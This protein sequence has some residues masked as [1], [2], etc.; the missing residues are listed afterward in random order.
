[1]THQIRQHPGTNTKSYRH[2]KQ[3]RKAR[4][5]GSDTRSNHTNATE[6]E[7]LIQMARSSQAR[8]RIHWIAGSHPHTASKLFSFTCMPG[9]CEAGHQIPA[10]T[11]HHTLPQ[12]VSE[13]RDMKPPVS[14][15][16][17]EVFRDSTKAR[18]RRHEQ[19]TSA[20][21]S[22]KSKLQCNGTYFPQ[23][24]VCPVRRYSSGLVR[25]AV[26]LAFFTGLVSVCRISH[27]GLAPYYKH[28]A[29][30]HL[31]GCP[32]PSPCSAPSLNDSP[33]HPTRASSP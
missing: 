14:N 17:T 1:M 28:H 27:T 5:H 23:S 30:V 2:C 8:N 10:P 11:H 20:R 22:V 15:Q 32:P 33:T 7:H 9:H 12:G 31:V 25:T 26:R 19:R 24:L 18:P 13:T 3:T 6:Q 21:N 16:P 29:T 4:T